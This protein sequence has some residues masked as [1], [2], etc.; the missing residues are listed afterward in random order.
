MT[1]LATDGWTP[2]GLG[3]IVCAK[4]QLNYD[5]HNQAR[6]TANAHGLRFASI[7]ILTLNANEVIRMAHHNSFCR[8]QLDCVTRSAF[9]VHCERGFRAHFGGKLLQTGLNARVV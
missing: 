8:S 4:R 3:P 9:C 1:V 5:K 6:R 7:I 2:G